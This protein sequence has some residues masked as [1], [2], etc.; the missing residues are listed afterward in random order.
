MLDNVCVYL[1][2]NQFMYKVDVGQ[3]GLANEAAAD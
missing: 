3:K 1:L 2:D